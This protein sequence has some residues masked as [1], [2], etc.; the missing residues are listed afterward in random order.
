MD[1]AML[2]VEDDV[3]LRNL[4]KEYL[5]EYGY[6]ILALPDGSGAVEMIRSKS[7][8]MVILDIMLPGKD[9]LEVLRDIRTESGGPRD[10][11]YGQ[12]RGYRPH[13]RAGT[14]SG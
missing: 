9:G 2:V 8:D 11:A 1:K 12:G 10:H 14:G 3:K 6:R 4:L 7:P 13:R 5:E